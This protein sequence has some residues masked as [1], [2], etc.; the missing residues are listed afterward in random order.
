MSRPYEKLF[1]ELFGHIDHVKGYNQ[2]RLPIYVY[3]KN[4]NHAPFMVEAKYR[5]QERYR[6]VVG[7]FQELEELLL[8]QED[9]RIFVVT[10][11]LHDEPYNYVR[12]ETIGPVIIFTDMYTGM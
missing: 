10:Q 6:K 5:I 8:K 7:D 9:R 4:D 12:Y 11:A 1:D 2:E 3:V